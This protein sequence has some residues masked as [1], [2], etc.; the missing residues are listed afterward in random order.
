MVIEEIDC[1]KTKLYTFKDD[2]LR[3]EHHTER[4]GSCPHDDYRARRGVYHDALFFALE[5]L[6][7][8]PAMMPFTPCPRFIQR[9]SSLRGMSRSRCNCNLKKDVG[10]RIIVS[11]GVTE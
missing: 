11:I 7:I 5:A 1:T 3:D 6:A 10:T 2:E 4:L 9:D 8:S